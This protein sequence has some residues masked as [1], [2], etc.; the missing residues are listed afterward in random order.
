[1]C[2]ED[3]SEHYLDESGLG[4]KVVDSFFAAAPPDETSFIIEANGE[5]AEVI[6]SVASAI[7]TVQKPRAVRS[8][9]ER[10]SFP[11]V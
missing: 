6:A 2:G 10:G 8:E 1:M 3:L 4:G 7:L 9:R 11:L 5:G